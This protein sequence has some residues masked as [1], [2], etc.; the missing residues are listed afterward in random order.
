MKVTS[1]AIVNGLIQDE[2]GKFGQ[3]FIDDMPSYSMPFQIVD[4]PKGTVSYAV[5]LD[6]KDSVPVCGFVWVHWLVAN[7]KKETVVANESVSD[8]VDFVQGNNSWNEPLYGGMAPPDKDHVY[9]LTV[10]ALD[11]ELSLQNGFSLTELESQMD[12]HILAS[13]CLQGKYR[14]F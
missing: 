10:Y 3:N 13:Y 2:Y 11:K 5:I 4:A 12:G 6:D 8:T 9:D 7:L 1:T 14:A